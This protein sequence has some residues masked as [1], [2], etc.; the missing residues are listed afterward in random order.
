MAKVTV[1]GQILNVRGHLV[2][3]IDDMQ[4]VLKTIGFQENEYVYINIQSV[5][6]GTKNNDKLCVGN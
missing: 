4:D 6:D 5:N 3:K 2:I 1:L